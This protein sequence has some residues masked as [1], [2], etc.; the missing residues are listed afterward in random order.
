MLWL[1]I[2]IVAV[3][4]LGWCAVSIVQAYRAAQNLRSSVDV[5]ATHARA[6]QSVELANDIPAVSANAEQFSNSVSGPLWSV[7]ARLPFLGSTAGSARDLAASALAMAAAAEQ[8]EPALASID[9]DTIKR[10]NGSIDLVALNEISQALEGAQPQLQQA[11]D[12]AAAADPGAMG[13]VGEAVATAQ[14]GLAGLPA[15][16]AG[17]V[18]ALEISTILLGGEGPQDWVVLLQNGSEARATGGFL[19][20]YALFTAD[21]GKLKVGTVDTNNSLTTRIPN[22]DMP[23]EFLDLWTTEYTSEWNSYNLSRHFPYTGQLTYNG[24][25]FR[26]TPIDN[27]L[28][29]DAHVVAALLAG[30]GPVTA[31]GE[32]IDLTNAERF[33]NADVYAR[34]PDTAQKD[35]VVVELMTELLGRVTSGNFDLLAAARA[36][37]PAAGQGRLLIWSDDKEVESRLA[38]YQVGGVI[39]RDP[40]PWV[41]T[42]LNNSA[43]NKLDAFIASSVDYQA[44]TCGTGPSMVTVT[45]TNNAP[46]PATSPDSETFA[47]S[48]YPKSAKGDTRMWTAIYGPVGAEIRSA[49]INGKREFISEGIERGHPVWRWNIEIPRGGSSVLTVTFDEPK[50]PSVPQV[51]PQ[52]MA[53]P[54]EVVASGGCPAGQNQD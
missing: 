24:M 31:A 44:A 29:I 19:G 2:V 45:M 1:G 17:A 23:R 54:Q 9:A 5:A 14:E 49:R 28:A 39:P 10:P 48:V 18:D 27:V 37:T 30:T 13:P 46:D 42:A 3:L 43:A 20:A 11:A 25:K 15:A 12:L 7:M 40:Q 51:P 8:L 53:V 4:I 21:D 22:R 38:T 32:T 50:S 34:Y 41:A 6:L 33:F 16:A 47:D 35:K 36:V 52:A 26:G